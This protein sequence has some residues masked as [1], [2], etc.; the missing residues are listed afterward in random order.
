[1]DR[2]VV[3][4]VFLNNLLHAHPVFQNC[5][6]VIREEKEELVLC[7]CKSTNSIAYRCLNASAFPPQL[8]GGL[9][10]CF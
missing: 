8:I 7:D 10:K 2:K 5:A 1:M 6:S 3:F 4:A 9:G